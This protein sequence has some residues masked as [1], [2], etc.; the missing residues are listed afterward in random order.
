LIAAKHAK[1]IV[2]SSR[3]ESLTATIDN[4][5]NREV[6]LANAIM[7]LQTHHCNF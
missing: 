6:E 7:Q 1:E 2:E 5:K 3:F 4:Y